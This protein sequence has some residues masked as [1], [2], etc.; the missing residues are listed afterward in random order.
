MKCTSF[1][2][3]SDVNMF[4]IV[5]ILRLWNNTLHC[6]N[7][8]GI[9]FVRS[10]EL[11]FCFYSSKKF[12][13]VT[14]VYIFSF[15]SCCRWDKGNTHRPKQACGCSRRSNCSSSWSVY[16]KVCIFLLMYYG[17]LWLQK[18]SSSFS[19]TP[20][21]RYICLTMFGLEM[22]IWRDITKCWRGPIWA[23]PCINNMYLSY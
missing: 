7:L 23:S 4:L 13:G 15:L 8:E 21:H 6:L 14:C 20:S 1:E 3:L 12:G 17:W 2:S 18:Q 11:D 9:C 22:I 16:H 10:G 5:S 19:S